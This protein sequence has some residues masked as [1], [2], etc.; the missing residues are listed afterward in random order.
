MAKPPTTSSA[1]EK[2]IQEK[3]ANVALDPQTARCLTE[4]REVIRA[5]EAGELGLVRY[6]DVLTAEDGM[7]REIGIKTTFVPRRAS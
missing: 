6:A 3:H 4:L 2:A 1:L 7:H 5:I